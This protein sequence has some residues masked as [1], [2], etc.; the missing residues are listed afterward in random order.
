M[1]HRE[2]QLRRKK[3]D[4]LDDLPPKQITTV[5][6]DLN[7]GQRESYDKAEREGIVYLKSLGAE[8]DVRHVP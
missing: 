3:G 5:T 4:V 6:I 2:L 7:P 8:V 1:R